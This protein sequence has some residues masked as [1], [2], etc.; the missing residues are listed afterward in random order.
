MKNFDKS[1][2][3][4]RPP[5]LSPTNPQDD[6]EKKIRRLRRLVDVTLALIAQSN[7]TLDEAQTLVQAVRAHAYSAF[8]DKKETYEII[9]APRFRRLIA[10]KFGMQ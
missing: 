2:H 1:S 8:P 9:Y 4:N 5:D 3:G 6:E 10:E 7:V